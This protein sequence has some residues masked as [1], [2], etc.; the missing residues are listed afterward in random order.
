MGE[1]VAYAALFLATFLA[2]ANL[3][4]QSKFLA[5][6]TPRL[7]LAVASFGNVL[8][9]VLNWI[10]GRGIERCRD[11]LWFLANPAVLS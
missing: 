7:V 3:L 2:A 11:R 5:V 8:G 1:V 10:L 6:R 4:A 9:S